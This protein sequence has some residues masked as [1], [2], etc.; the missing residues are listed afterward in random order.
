MSQDMYG[1][2]CRYQGKTVRIN[3][4][5]GR[6]HVGL[7]TRVS[8][9]RVFIEPASQRGGLGGY[10]YG[11]YGGRYGGYGGGYGGRYGG[12]GYGGY[13]VALGAI[14]GIALAGLFFW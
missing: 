4:H 3:E 12:Y 14:A 11:F 1:M 10:G 8:R 7:I 5:N 9:D 2:C 6:N 13:G